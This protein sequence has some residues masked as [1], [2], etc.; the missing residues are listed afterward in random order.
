MLRDEEAK[1]AVIPGRNAPNRTQGAAWV[2]KARA[3]VGVPVR[4]LTVWPSP[5]AYIR[6]DALMHT[7]GSGEAM[8]GWALLLLS[9]T[10]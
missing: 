5:G 10:G 4:V 8:Q 9:V 2:R 1:Y 7:V 3:R 6:Q